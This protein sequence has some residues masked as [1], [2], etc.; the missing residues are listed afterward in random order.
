M[1]P[2]QRTALALIAIVMVSSGAAAIFWW[3]QSSRDPVDTA[4]VA[5]AY[6]AV[7]AIA[8]TL[9][10]PVGPWWWKSRDGA[11]DH[12]STPVQAAAAAEWLARATADRWQQEA[13][14]RR[15]ITP[16]PATVRWRWV[17]DQLTA[18]RSEVA[19]APLP[20]VGPLPL[21]DAARPSEVL[22]SG[23]V[24]R[25][26]DELY[27][28]L[29]NGRLVLT[30]GPGSGKTGAMVLLLLS[31]LG[32][33]ARLAADQ[34]ERMPVPVWLTLGGWNPAVTPLRVWAAATMERD[35][36]ALRAPAY[37][38][39]A[40]GEL[41]R[42][43]LVALFLD[44]LDEM[45]ESA[46][47]LALS[48]VEEE[49]R[50]LR[51]VITS[52]P[53]E[54]HSAARAGTPGRTA[55]VELRPLRPKAA[56]D[57][58]TDG[59]DEDSR[60]AWEQ[61]GAYL[62]ANPD[63]M[64]ARALD[65]PLALSLARDTY[66]GRDPAVLIDPARFGTVAAVREHLLRQFLITA[67]PGERERAH[68]IRWLAWIASHMEAG[69]DLRWWDIPGWIPQWRLRLARGLAAG[70]TAG[71]TAAIVEGL[72]A[73]VP[74]GR[75]DA[76]K[77]GGIAGIIAGTIALLIG[78]LARLNKQISPV[79]RRVFRRAS[80]IALALVF[81]FAMT[82]VTQGVAFSFILLHTSSERAAA[83]YFTSTPWLAAFVFLAFGPERMIGLGM[84]G[85]PMALIPRRPHGWE[86]CWIIAIGLLFFPLLGPAFLMLW[87]I[88]TASSPSF[89]A[90]DT[91]RV[92][93]RTSLIRS[94]IYGFTFASLNGFLFLSVTF[95]Q[96]FVSPEI[97][98]GDFSLTLFVGSLVIGVAVMLEGGLI[99]WLVAGQSP[100]VKLVEL[101][102]IRPRG[103][104]RFLQLL[105][106]AS[107]RQVLRQAGTLYQFRHAELQAH[108][109][110]MHDRPLT[111]HIGRH[112]LIWTCW[113]GRRRKSCSRQDTGSSPTA[114]TPTSSGWSS[115]VTSPWTCGFPARAQRSSAGSVPVDLWAGLGCSRPTS[116]CSERYAS[117]RSRRSSL[118]RRP[119]GISVRPIRLCG[120]SSPSACS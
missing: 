79:S 27:A 75:A 28:R 104:V 116:G 94:L 34:R 112:H 36:P 113:P 71:I 111:G 44:G 90:A 43:G 33:R 91:Y 64:A 69:Q 29:P 21:S 73:G 24:R 72:F 22:A 70:T 67:Y 110:A 15:I 102:L 93:R 51:V 46:R 31:T 56:A 55:V 84:T 119:S 100:L 82:I 35:Y 83:Y 74:E 61:V 85:A 65:N 88:P 103:R 6:L 9:L 26:H 49:A 8:V 68:A 101:T 12:G 41:L 107:R 13:G 54:Y 76:L 23:V 52:R 99:T 81:G 66:V 50:G 117:A 1:R 86:V 39:D 105:E 25:I 114:S 5:A 17:S 77:Y 18:S 63:S 14:A 60:R 40:A 58:L 115:P 92:D 47:F 98:A 16:A 53:G 45:P 118:M 108:L 30:G 106:D 32:Q 20:G 95:Y 11:A 7:A 4:T 87:A 10:A 57:Y 109:A 42:C 2:A 37:G 120:A 97:Y 62:I 3:I 48:R 89:T 78:F 38:P 96:I 59:Q 19:A 80:K